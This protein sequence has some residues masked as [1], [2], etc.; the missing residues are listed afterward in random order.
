[1]TYAEVVEKA[2]Q[3]MDKRGDD[4]W[5]TKVMFEPCKIWKEGDQINLWTYWQGYQIKDVDNGVDILLVGQDYGN[6]RSERNEK[7]VNSIVD[8]QHGEDV[9]Y[10]IGST[11]DRTL[12]NLFNANSGQTVRIFRNE[13]CSHSDLAVRVF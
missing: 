10:F 4:Y 8:I 1:M 3:E 5:N 6:P 7:T 13:R 2:K 11:T 12:E 9:L